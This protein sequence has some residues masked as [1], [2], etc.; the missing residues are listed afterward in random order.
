ALVVLVLEL[1]VGWLV[2][3]F[4]GDEFSGAVVLTRIL[5][6]GAL[7]LS[8]RRMLTDGAQGLGRPGLGTIAEVSSW[9]FLLPAL[10]VFAPLWGARG[11]ALALAVSSALS[12][13]VLLGLLVRSHAA[14]EPAAA[15][16]LR[17]R[18]AE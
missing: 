4:F 13:A 1:S 2:P 6:V 12:F 11:V 10:G 17:V 16:A 14:G 15:P 9:G 3:F 8:A 7:F 18:G 5:L